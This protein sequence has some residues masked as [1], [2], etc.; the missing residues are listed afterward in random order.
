MLFVDLDDDTYDDLIAAV[1][2]EDEISVLLAD[3]VG[4]LLGEAPFDAGARPVFSAVGL[5]N[6]GGNL[7]IAYVNLN[8]NDMGVRMGNG[9]GTFGAETLY[10]FGSNVDTTSV[11]AGDIDGDGELD[12][13]VS[14]L[15]TH[16]LALFSG[17][18]DGTFEDP[19]LMPVCDDPN[20]I[21]IGDVDDDGDNDVVYACLGGGGS[22]DVL[23]SGGAGAFAEV[24]SF[25]T[26]GQAWAVAL[27]DFNEDGI[28][29]IAVTIP[30]NDEVGL[31]LSNP[32]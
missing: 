13:A 25:D 11:A 17:N 10:D 6:G 9:D 28:N 22:V 7:D 18:G 4:S 1:R 20:W 32:M 15:A 31:I 8:S 12:L 16:E 3:G 14:L 2:D 24:V 27:A 23:L 5:F 26:G 29:D 19:V 30:A 21:A